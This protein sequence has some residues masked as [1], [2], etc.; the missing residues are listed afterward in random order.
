MNLF[1]LNIETV[2]EHWKCEHGLREIIANALDER[3]LTCT[4]PISIVKDVQGHWH[5]RD[6]GRGIRIEHFTLNENREKIGAD[7][8]IGKFGVGLKD[9]LATLDRH[10]ANVSI[11]SRHGVFTLTKAAK[12][13]F[14]GITTLHISHEPGDV[15]TITGTDVIL[16]N[17]P[18][19]AIEQ[20][21]AMFLCFR[22]HIVLEETL[23]GQ[24]IDAPPTK[25]QVFIN[26]VW[27]NA[28]P[29]FLFSYNVT[30]LT[31]SMRKALNR[32]RVNVGR[33][34][35]A[36]RLRQ[37]LKY[38]NAADV[39]RRLASTYARRDE[40][41]LPEELG[42][43]DVA[44]KAL[45]ELAKSRRIV[46]MSNTEIKDRPQLVEDIKSDGFQ[47]VLLTEREKQ[48]ADPQAEQGKAP[49]Q[50]RST[51]IKSINDSFQYRFIDA[52]QF[53]EDERK[54][55]IKRNQI[56]GLVGISPIAIPRILVSETMRT[57]EDGTVGVWDSKLKAIVVKRTQLRSLPLF[58]GTLL[59]EL[60]H[61]TTGAPD[62]TRLFEYILTMYLG[63]VADRAL[64]VGVPS[65]EHN[66]EPQ[67]NVIPPA[68]ETL[69]VLGGITFVAVISSCIAGVS[70][71]EQ[72]QALYVAFKKGKLYVFHEVPQIEY[73]AFLN[74]SSKGRYLSVL[75][76]RYEYTSKIN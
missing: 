6:F 8:V 29:T 54:I 9:A 60:A 15:T 67:I 3:T 46:V 18:D 73:T 10:H 49:F 48:R 56:L 36:D 37:I 16:K 20:A 38:A 30:R 22:E 63:K 25:A 68:P 55:W 47:I 51:W 21:K 17:I 32:E 24:I 41:E 52:N 53:T 35:Y 42:W 1:D 7:G 33:S 28:E 50:T 58:A 14:D 13:D 44:H 69:I 76:N 40:G 39:L 43:I 64:S 65:V 19:S 11:R 59:H 61:C 66:D 2:L 72:T 71:N 31:D 5:I 62:C 27:A 4:S 75:F 74:A 57:S 45:N 23:F 70:Y 34:V 12:H 26:G